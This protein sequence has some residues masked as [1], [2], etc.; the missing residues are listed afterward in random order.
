MG[1]LCTF[2][3]NT[4]GNGSFSDSWDLCLQNLSRY[5][6][7]STIAKKSFHL[8]QESA[9]RLLSNNPQTAYPTPCP[10]GS[11]IQTSNGQENG[12][13]PVGNFPDTPPEKDTGMQSVQSY[14]E[15]D[16]YGYPAIETDNMEDLGSELWNVDPS[17]W[18]FMP[19]L[20]QLET[21][22]TNFDF[23]DIDP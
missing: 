4:R 14:Q 9:E 12:M 7:L 2:S 8:L 21:F 15:Q 22:P 11:Y 18:S 23:S 10:Q 19:F 1:Q 6:T 5:T 3:D 13:Q 20:S 17:Y 16:F